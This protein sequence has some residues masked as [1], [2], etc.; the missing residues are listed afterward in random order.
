MQTEHAT[1]L[2]FV[3]ERFTGLA[4]TQDGRPVVFADAPG[5][6]QV[7]QQVI[8]AMA[9]YLANWNANLGGAFA[10]SARSDRVVAE[11]H[12][13]GAAFLGADP[14][15]VIVGQ[16]TTTLAF[17]LARSFGRTLRPADE[18]VVTVLDHDANVTPWIRAAEDAGATVRLVDVREKDGT[19]DLES[20]DAALGDRTR[21]VAF[22]MASN[23]LGTVTPAAEIVRRV[24]DAGALA[25]ADAVHFAPHNSIDVRALGVDVLFTS[26]YKYFG[27]HLGV[28]FGRR[29]LLERWVPYKVRPAPDAL[30]D[31]WETGTLSHEALAGLSAAVDYLAGLVE[32]GGSPRDRLVAGMTAV[33][34]Y[35][36][37]LTRR[38]LSAAAGIPGLTLYGIADPDRWV[39][40][41]PTFAFRLDSMAPRALAEELGRRGIFVW[42]GNYYALSIMERLGLEE[43]GGAVRVGFCHY[44]T[45]D[46][47]DR[48][49]AA[50]ADIAAG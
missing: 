48:V 11:A 34:A 18:V 35:E 22:T 28:A 15:E 27:P 29:E 2:S 1:D 31:R 3:R 6:T 21:L 47:V 9:D 25:V 41:T 37:S 45:A 50:L 33:T 49:V 14:D 16:N 12:A 10:T 38:F 43:S 4:R 26:P 19:L 8:D 17:H 13:A 40:R 24:H 36:G 20:L 32:D 42:D 44:N 30:P 7:P 23:A 5:G 39:E 46:E